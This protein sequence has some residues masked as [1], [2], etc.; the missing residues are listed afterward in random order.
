MTVITESDFQCKQKKIEKKIKIKVRGQKRTP[1][2]T[3]AKTESKNGESTAVD[4]VEKKNR[5]R[6]S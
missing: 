2:L 3:T 1:R 5:C 6:I 4:I